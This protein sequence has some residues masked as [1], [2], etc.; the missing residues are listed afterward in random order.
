MVGCFGYTKVPCSQGFS[1]VPRFHQ[2]HA[3]VATVTTTSTKTSR[4]FYRPLDEDDDES[5]MLKVNIR[6]PPGFDLKEA[7]RPPSIPQSSEQP[8][9]DSSQS[10]V[11]RRRHGMNMPLIQALVLNQGLLL[12]LSTLV[13]GLFV[14]FHTDDLAQLAAPDYWWALAHWSG[15]SSSSTIDTPLWIPIVQGMVGALPLVTLSHWIES[16][17]RRIFAQ[18]NFS[19]I[20]MSLTLFG[21]QTSATSTK[22]RTANQSDQPTINGPISNGPTTNWP[23]ALIQSLRLSVVTGLCEEIVFRCQVP[24]VLTLMLADSNTATTTDTTV[25]LVWLGQAVLFAMGHVQPRVSLL[26]NAIVFGLQCFNGLALG[27]LYV[28]TGG[29]L[30]PSIVAHALYDFL[31]FY[32]T[33]TTANTQLDYAETMALEPLSRDETEQVQRALQLT[34]NNNNNN[35]SSS[36]PPMTR[37]LYQSIQRL[38]YLFDFDQ[39]QSLSLSE[40]RKGTAYMVLERAGTPPPTK[41]IDQL[42]A[43]AI[44]ARDPTL[45]PTQPNDRLLFPDFVYMFGTMRQ[46]MATRTM[47]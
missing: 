3:T 35:D 24:A 21:R 17:D 4:R 23:D 37:D 41:Q 32:Q 11:R 19:T 10:L 15:G 5:A 8:L 46:R 40:V 9:Q 6:A 43:H 39:N 44:A 25:A 7:V 22:T 38:F 45:L 1:L 28:V 30:V 47:R 29:N 42:F 18:I 33:W 26:E 14:L 34:A 36:P 27:L 20:V 31:T 13:S 2:S 12:S 16:S